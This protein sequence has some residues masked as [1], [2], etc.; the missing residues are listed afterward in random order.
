MSADR[1]DLA[2]QNPAAWAAMKRQEAKAF[3]RI[4]IEVIPHTEQRLG[5]PGDWYTAADGTRVVRVSDLGD[6]RFNYLLARHEMDEMMLCQHAGISV[7]AVDGYDSR[8]EAKDDDP[9]SFSGYPGAPYQEQHND[10]M[11]AEWVMSRLLNVAWQK[12]G[13]AFEKLWQRRPVKL[14]EAPPRKMVADQ[15]KG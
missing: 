4:I 7:E 10:A 6:W 9:D 15:D 1:D 12:Y 11:A 14:T 5:Q 8:P 13:E 3:R 2:G